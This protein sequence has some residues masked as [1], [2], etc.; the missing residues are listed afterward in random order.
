MKKSVKIAIVSTATAVFAVAAILI[1]IIVF[2]KHFSQKKDSVPN[3]DY[4]SVVPSDEISSA[5]E[6]NLPHEKK[7]PDSAAV[8]EENPKHTESVDN[9]SATSSSGEIDEEQLPYKVTAQFDVPDTDV[10]AFPQFESNT[11]N[12]IS[13]GFSL[14]Y[15]LYVPEDYD[16][17]KSYPIFFFLHGAGERGSDNSN[18]IRVLENAYRVA[19]DLLGQAIVLAPQCPENG[20]WNIDGYDGSETG[21]L[22]AAMRLLRVTIAQYRC[23]KERVYVAGLSM[24]GYATWSVLERY[25]EIFA[26][27][28]PICGWGNSEMGYRLAKIPIWVYH[29]T[30]DPTVSYYCSEEMVNAI[31]NAGG[32]MI[33]LTPLNGVG[34]NA[35]DTALGTRETFLWMFGQTKSRG[36]AGDDSYTVSGLFRL[37]SPNG[38]VILTEAD[39]QGIGGKYIGG[40]TH[41]LAELTPEA[42]VRLRKAYAAGKGQEF[43]VEYLGRPYYRFCPVGTL[44]SDEFVFAQF[45]KDKF[46]RI[47]QNTL[48]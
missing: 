18:H 11:Y 21:W 42:G 46:L 16:R 22:G 7:N 12:D 45:A 3:S 47:L 6:E 44:Q 2:P 20:W 4:S 36:A 38:E 10:F 31:R 23:D 28:V 34:H 13:T 27:G 19:G 48:Y 39:I 9:I 40:R 29:G 26:A 43:T 35:W 1:I 37:L 24:G 33:R 15:R 30:D 5:A 41:L 8:S 32:R 17:A 14:P 25:G